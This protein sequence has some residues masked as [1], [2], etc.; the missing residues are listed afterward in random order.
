MS[1]QD[2]RTDSDETTEADTEE[3]TVAGREAADNVAEELKGQEEQIEE[4]E[5]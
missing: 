2:E 4:G 3:P 1:E 5:E